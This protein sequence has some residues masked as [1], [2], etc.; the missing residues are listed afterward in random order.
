VPPP[1][2][3]ILASGSRYRRE[4]LARLLPAFEVVLPGVDEQPLAG[5]LPAALAARLAEAKARAVAVSRPAA[6][7]I[8]SDQVASVD[9]RVLGKPGSAAR[10]VEQLL[11]CAGREVVFHTAVAVAG[12]RGAS[13]LTHTDRTLVRFRPFD[14]D[15]ARAYV[16]A[17]EPY[18]CA[19]SFKAEQRGVVLMSALLSQDPTA[20]QGLPLIWLADAL[21]DRGVPLP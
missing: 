1:V 11:A 5:E 16:A 4:L 12:P 15:F 18:D 8:G 3:V 13:L 14:A 21:R 19:G 2:A 9:G 6:L 10:A 7:V 17:D 20:I